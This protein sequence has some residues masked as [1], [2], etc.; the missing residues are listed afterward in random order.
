MNKPLQAQLLRLEDAYEEIRRAGSALGDE[1]KIAILLGCA[2][3]VLKTHISF[4]LKEN[5][6]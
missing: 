2:T 3:G 5:S 6:K 4:N 1:V